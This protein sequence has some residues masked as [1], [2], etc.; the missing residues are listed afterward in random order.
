MGDMP[1]SE[2]EGQLGDQMAFVTGCM[3]LGITQQMGR[4][5]IESGKVRGYYMPERPTGGGRWF[6]SR[7]AVAD[8]IKHRKHTV[9]FIVVKR[10]VFASGD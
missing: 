6:W 8:E 2:A 10:S 3:A 9:A 7:A 4:R 5:L 1:G